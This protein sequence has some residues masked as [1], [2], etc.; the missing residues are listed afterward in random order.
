[1]EQLGD[2][3]GRVEENIPL[4]ENDAIQA[5]LPAGCAVSTGRDDS[6]SDEAA[7]LLAPKETIIIIRG[8]C[9]ARGGDE[10]MEGIK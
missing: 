3:A 5:R 10:T 2:V 6:P 8:R 4:G 9:E 7:D 1:M